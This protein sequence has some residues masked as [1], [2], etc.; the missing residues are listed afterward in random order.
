MD[1]PR[2]FSL[3]AF[4]GTRVG[5]YLKG[6]RLPDRNPVE[7]LHEPIQL[8]FDLIGMSALNVG[9]WKRPMAQDGVSRIVILLKLPATTRAL[10]LLKCSLSRAIG[11]FE[12][13]GF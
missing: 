1:S 8:P 4:T 9:T 7:E 5:M 10:I 13:M 3:K 6:V 2:T 11:R 12:I